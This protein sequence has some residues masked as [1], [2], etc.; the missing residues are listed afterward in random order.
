MV[1][2]AGGGNRAV[3]PPN[4]VGPHRTRLAGTLSDED[5]VAFAADLAEVPRNYNQ[6]DDGT[7]AARAEYLEAVGV[8]G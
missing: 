8:R 5:L 7:V 3:F 1:S 6:A 2:A 4:L